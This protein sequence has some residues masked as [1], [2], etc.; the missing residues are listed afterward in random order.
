MT[1]IANW[2]KERI[3]VDRDQLRELTNEPVPN[4]LNDKL[5]HIK[6]CPACAAHVSHMIYQH[7]DAVAS[8]PGREIVLF[9]L[10]DDQLT[11]KMRGGLWMLRPKLSQWLK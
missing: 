11:P 4:H 9:H 1:S 5:G 2:F 8:A 3:P 7:E 6:K 10:G